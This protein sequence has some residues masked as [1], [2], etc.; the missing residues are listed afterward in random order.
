MTLAID[1]ITIDPDI[2]NGKP[3]IRSLRITVESILDYLS[4][5][6]SQEEILRQYP[7]LEPED[8]SACL[9]FASRL[10][11]HSYSVKQSA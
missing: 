11:G 8:I 4:V 3:V 7:M 2:C 1:R 10:M 6:E 5:G 9:A